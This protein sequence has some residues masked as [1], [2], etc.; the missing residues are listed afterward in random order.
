RAPRLRGDRALL[1]AGADLARRFGPASIGGMSAGPSP[2]TARAALLVA[3]LACASLACDLERKPAILEL[4]DARELT[5]DLRAQLHRSG[6][7]AQRTIL[8]DDEEAAAGFRREAEEAIGALEHDLESLRPILADLRFEP[9]AGLL[10]DVEQ[11]F[12]ELRKLDETLL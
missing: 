10:R 12:A 3:G 6:E 9:E 7:A 2:R 1:E 5:A 11:P 8:A 4:S